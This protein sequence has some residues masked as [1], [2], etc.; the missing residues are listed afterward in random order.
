MRITGRHNVYES[1]PET[2]TTVAT[3]FPRST[4]LPPPT[5]IIKSHRSIPFTI[6]QTRSISSKL[7]INGIL[8]SY[9]HWRPI[10]MKE[11]LTFAF[12]IEFSTIILFSIHCF[13]LFSPN[14]LIPPSEIRIIQLLSLLRGE[15]EQT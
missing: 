8:L 7:D 5:E 9:L 10:R 6:V 14:R 12:F 2:R 1:S 3:P 4:A 11:Y 13:V 15:I